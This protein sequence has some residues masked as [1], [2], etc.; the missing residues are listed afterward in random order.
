MTS[1]TIMFTVFILGGAT[2]YVLDKLGFSL[3][4]DPGIM[5]M[6]SSLVNDIRMD[7]DKNSDTASVSSGTSASRQR[8]RQI[9][10]MMK[11]VSGTERLV[12]HRVPGVG[13]FSS[14]A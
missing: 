7:D 8:D 14:F 13:T 3:N 2:S 5:E 9:S 11:D 6:S 12:R 10:D 1:A 4:K